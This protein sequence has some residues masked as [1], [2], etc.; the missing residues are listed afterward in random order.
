MHF[1]EGVGGGGQDLRS[2][3]PAGR[4]SCWNS[5]NRFLL[6]PD[7]QH[8]V[9][10]W[11][12]SQCSLQSSPH[13]CFSVFYFSV[14]PFLP[15]PRSSLLPSHFKSSKGAFLP[16]E[17]LHLCSEFC[18]TF[19]LSA[20]APHCQ[21]C[22][23]TPYLKSP[24]SIFYLTIKASGTATSCWWAPTQS[25]H[26]HRNSS[27][28][29]L[30]GHCSS[31][32]SGVAKHPKKKGITATSQKHPR[33]RVQ[34]KALRLWWLWSRRGDKPETCEMSCLE[35]RQGR[36]GTRVCICVNLCAHNCVHPGTAAGARTGERRQEPWRVYSSLYVLNKET[37]AHHHPTVPLNCYFS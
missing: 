7:I 18:W 32:I 2:T 36:T 11:Q 33:L 12:V 13:P 17:A 9:S 26:S 22:H 19:P 1:G 24:Q 10:F 37:S 3:K 16:S 28:N 29:E 20:I 23:R 8:S 25:S 31:C 21:P 6:F 5:Q 15:L 34:T 27:S 4:N 35:H 14:P 30:K